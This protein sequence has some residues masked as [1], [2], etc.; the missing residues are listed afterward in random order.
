MNMTTHPIRRLVVAGLAAAVGLAAAATG[1][2]PTAH[3]E[4]AGLDTGLLGWWKL[5]ETSGTVAADSSGNGRD[6]TV[7]GTATWN[8]G[9]GFT[10]SGGSSSSGNYIKLPDNLMAGVDDLT[11]DFDVWVDPAL[12]GNWFMYNLGNS[13]LWPNGTGYLFTTNDSSGRYRATIAEGA[14]SSEQSAS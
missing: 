7:N 12:S 3:A 5:D 11:V 4:D 6:G 8:G 9:Q 1:P 13:A 14:F 2:A 10:F